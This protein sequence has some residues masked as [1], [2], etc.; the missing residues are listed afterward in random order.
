ML[1]AQ[2]LYLYALC[3]HNP[4]EHF[5]PLSFIN[6]KMAALVGFLSAEM[7]R[8]GIQSEGNYQASAIHIHFTGFVM[9]PGSIL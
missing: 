5:I 1:Y 7:G 9:I 2:F 3:S 8:E 4:I 6:R